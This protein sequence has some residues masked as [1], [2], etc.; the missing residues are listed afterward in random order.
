MQNLK[1]IKNIIFDLGNVLI[2]LQVQKAGEV[3]QN[4]MNNGLTPEAFI[5]KHKEAFRAYETGKISTA[6]FIEDLRQDLAP[7]A[8]DNQI[9]DAWNTVLGNFPARHVDLLLKLRPHFRL[10]IL[11]NTNELHAKRFE[12]E[13]PG[14]SH[15]AELFDGLH[16]SHIEGLR[17]PQPELYEKVIR[18]NELVPSETLFADDLKEN[19]DA[20]EKFGIKTLHVT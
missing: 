6:W 4:L 15:I 13:V 19:L 1:G 14:V 12:T 17:K 2:P 7:E 18:T 3:F 5:E 20:A 16:Y 10:Y 11:S 9:T 8:S